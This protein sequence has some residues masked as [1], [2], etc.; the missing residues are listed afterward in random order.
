MTTDVRSL[1]GELNAARDEATKA[2]TE[3]DDLLKKVETLSKDTAAADPD[4]SRLIQEKTDKIKALQDTLLEWTD[5]AKRSYDEYKA[6]LPMS[7]E[8]E[9]LRQIVAQKDEIIKDLQEKVAS[10]TGSA[11]ID[12]V[13]Y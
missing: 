8:A 10:S 9:Q 1:T 11:S 13:R 6:L 4:T 12:S 3:R 5:L 2:K 7:K